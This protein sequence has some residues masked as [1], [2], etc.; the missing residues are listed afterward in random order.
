MSIP[1]KAE[2]RE[3]FG[4]AA[5]KKLRNSGQI[6]AIIYS[7]KGNV[8]LSV[9]SREFE[10]EYHRSDILTKVIELELDGKKIKAIPHRIDV[11]PVSDR[12]THIDFIDLQG[13]KSIKAKPKV[14]FKGREKSPGLKKGGFLHV[15]KRRVSVLCKDESVIPETLEV[16]IDSLHMAAKIYSTDITLPEGVKYNQK[17]KFLIA[18]IIG[19]GKSETEETAAA[20]VPGAEGQEGAAEEDQG[21]APAEGAESSEGGSS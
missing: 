11:D 18:S 4:T 10:K 2:K 6:P 13:A 8:N 20:T 15:V 5:T 14:I 3:K 9:N 17:G 1:F 16:R 21:E 19:R 12:P 7:E